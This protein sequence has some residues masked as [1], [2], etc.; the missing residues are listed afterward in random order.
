MEQRF[1]RGR[2]IF[3]GRRSL[4]V[5]FHPHEFRKKFMRVDAAKDGFHSKKH[6][7]SNTSQRK[8][9]GPQGPTGWG[10][11]TSDTI[12]QITHSSFGSFTFKGKVESTE[13]V[14]TPHTIE[15]FP[16]TGGGTRRANRL[17]GPAGEK[18]EPPKNKKPK[19]GRCERLG[20]QKDNPGAERRPTRVRT[21]QVRGTRVPGRGGAP[22]ARP[23]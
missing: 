5:D 4:E 2:N 19:T 12:D 21:T 22:P 9:P 14:S 13:G 3:F 20:W 18:T 17:E 11:R 1:R 15:G 6:A 16:P 23:C 8:V 10:S 7:I